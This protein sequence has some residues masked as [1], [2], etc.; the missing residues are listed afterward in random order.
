MSVP[1]VLVAHRAANAPDTLRAA[2]GDVD[3]VEADVHLF[4]GRLEVR[5]AKTL[6]PLPVLW[7]KWHLLARDTPRPLLGDL[8]SVAAPLAVDLML[9]L[10]GPDPRLP[11]ALERALAGWKG[12][13]RLIVCS[14]IWRTVDRLL[15]RPSLRL[16]IAIQR[17]IEEPGLW[18]LILLLALLSWTT[19][20]RVTRAKVMQV[21]ELEYVQAAKALGMGHLRI[22]WRHVLPN[23]LGPIIVLGTTLV[24]RMIIFE[25]A[26]SFLGLGVQPPDASW[27][28]MLHDGSELMITYPRLMLY[29]AVMIVITVFGF[30]L[31]GE[32]LRDA[33]D[34]K[35]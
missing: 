25:S 35:E 5:H 13:R 31:L 30:N 14:R 15:S 27:G 11:G 24:A 3:V 22:L 7:E 29:P 8:L 33:F 9:D 18:V 20:A 10:K 17:V 6:G 19:L 26:L 1:G 16:A 2:T 23:V 4:R 32:G 28:S 34:P 12:E 21:R